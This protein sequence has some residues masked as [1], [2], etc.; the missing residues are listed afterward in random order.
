MKDFFW[1]GGG[2]VNWNI[3]NTRVVLGTPQILEIFVHQMEIKVVSP[4]GLEHLSLRFVSWLSNASS[5]L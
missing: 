5:Y 1:G 2:S 3:A 4:G